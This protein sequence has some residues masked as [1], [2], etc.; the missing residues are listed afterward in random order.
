MLLKHLKNERG[1]TLLEVLAVLTLLGIVGAVTFNLLTTSVTNTNKTQS[2]IDLRQEA[3]ILLSLLRQK[4]SVDTPYELNADNLIGRSDVHFEQIFINSQSLLDGPL[5][6]NIEEHLHVV[7]TLNDEQNQTFE[8][9]TIIEKRYTS[10]IDPIDLPTPD[11]KAC[12]IYTGSTN[13]WD[14]IR[15]ALDLP[16]PIPANTTILIEGN[17]IIPNGKELKGISKDNVSIYITGNLTVQHGGKVS[18]ATLHVQGDFDHQSGGHIINTSIVHV[19][20]EHKL[21]AGSSSQGEIFV[22]TA[23]DEGFI[24]YVDPDCGAPSNPDNPSNPDSNE[25]PPPNDSA[26][27]DKD[28]FDSISFKPEDYPE[29]KFSKHQC[30][31]TGNAKLSNSNF[32][33]NFDWA[34]CTHTYINGGVFF[35]E[36]LGFNGGYKLT[37]TD[38][39]FVRKESWGLNSGGEITVKGNAVFF[40]NLPQNGANVIVQQN[41]FVKGSTHLNTQSKLKI[42][43]SARFDGDLVLDN[44]SQLSVSHHLFGPPRVTLNGG[45]SILVEGNAYFNE[46]TVFTTNN[47]STIKVKGHV[48][49]G[50]K[51]YTSN[52]TYSNVHFIVG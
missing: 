12:S 27:T 51:V 1:I 39:F 10:N 38:N 43:G 45:S 24:P 36:G 11:G 21:A 34:P 25:P 30:E 20:G 49:I 18:G 46:N 4:H 29:K 2:H 35:S 26:F 7:F 28:S 33:G 52:F 50:N 17:L 40:N 31:Y 15:S 6:P 47:G 23:G 8:V 13:Y 37:V 16:D 32:A 9:D 14:T 5:S 19:S 22:Y 41:F 3:N 48:Q 42:G 44:A